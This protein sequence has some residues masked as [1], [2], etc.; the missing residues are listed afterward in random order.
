MRG[1]SSMS[2]VPHQLT[3]LLP[4]P[5]VPEFIATLHRKEPGEMRLHCLVGSRSPYLLK[6]ELLY[7]LLYTLK[8][9]I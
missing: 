6:T 9:T 2:G 3:F 5:Q 1:W 4:S 8:F 7:I